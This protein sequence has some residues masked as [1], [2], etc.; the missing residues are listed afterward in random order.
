MILALLLPLCMIIAED[1]IVY[2]STS[3]VTFAEAL[4]RNG[5]SVI[6]INRSA[7]DNRFGRK[8]YVAGDSLTAL[9]ESTTDGVFIRFSLSGDAVL[10]DLC[11]T[12]VAREHNYYV[13]LSRAGARALVDEWNLT[14][15]DAIRYPSEK[16]EGGI[17]YAVM[18]PSILTP[19]DILK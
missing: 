4:M 5:S 9:K 11:D 3:S 8:F 7:D 17:S 13:G 2:H 14:G 19:I 15:Y 10:L 1:R 18:N 6:D 16:N 12:I